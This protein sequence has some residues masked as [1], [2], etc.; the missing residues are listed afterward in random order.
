MGRDNKMPTLDNERGANLFVKG[1]NQYTMGKRQ[2]VGSHSVW[3][4]C[5]SAKRERDHE[6]QIGIRKNKTN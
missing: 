4:N 6:L 1:A 3:K 5:Q 2:G